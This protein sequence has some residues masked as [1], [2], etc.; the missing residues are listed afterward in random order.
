MTEHA[1]E[2]VWSQMVD[3]GD[4]SGAES[5][6]TGSVDLAE[7]PEVTDITDELNGVVRDLTLAL[8]AATDFLNSP[9]QPSSLAESILNDIDY[10]QGVLS[11]TI[12][13][14]PHTA[15]RIAGI[16]PKLEAIALL[17]LG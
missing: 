15:L 16:T 4:Y 6:A 11:Q 3:E 5:L 7:T 1:R 17:R 2:L 9:D 12:G 10:L 8:M 14:E 13:I